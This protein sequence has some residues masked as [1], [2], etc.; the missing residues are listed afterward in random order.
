MD[1]LLE[2]FGAVARDGGERYTVVVGG[3]IA[4]SCDFGDLQAAHGL[5]LDT[6]PDRSPGSTTRPG[7]VGQLWQAEE[8]IMKKVS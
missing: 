3:R 7:R 4:R 8:M 2:E 5:V 1:G 6:L